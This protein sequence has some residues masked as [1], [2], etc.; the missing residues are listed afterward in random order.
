MSKCKCWFGVIN[1]LYSNEYNIESPELSY[2]EIDM[3]KELTE[4]RELKYILVGKTELINLTEIIR[5][6]IIF[7]VE[8]NIFDSNIFKDWKDLLDNN[9]SNIVLSEPCINNNKFLIQFNIIQNNYILDIIKRMILKMN[10][11][12][13]NT[14]IENIVY[15]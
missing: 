1:K 10:L 15:S 6:I 14:E 13:A 4:Y 9:D 3:Y 12:Y 11:Y 5:F 8:I 2:Q 7:D